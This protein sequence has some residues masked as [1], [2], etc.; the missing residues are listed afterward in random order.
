SGPVKGF[1]T[2]KFQ[3]EKRAK[4][5][6]TDASGDM[7]IPF[8]CMFKEESDSDQ[9]LVVISKDRAYVGIV[10]VTREQ[11]AKTIDVK[12]APACK[13][14]VKL[15][16]SAL[17]QLGQ[18]LAW[19]TVDT[20]SGESRLFS[21]PGVNEM[22]EAPLPPGTYKALGYGTSTYPKAQAFTV[23]VGEKEKTITLDLPPS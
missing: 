20:Y 12:L 5:N 15:T 9:S 22:H 18:K 6:K 13:V 2:G 11:A 21:I 7:A 8:A 19:S 23:A 1:L 3:C 10:S 17:E 16:S 14:T 4:A